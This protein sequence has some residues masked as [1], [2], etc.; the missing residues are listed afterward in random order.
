MFLHA[1]LILVKHLLTF[2]VIICLRICR[3]FKNNK[4]RTTPIET[5]AIPYDTLDVSK[6]DK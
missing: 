1:N 6:M 2:F 4:D 3:C 5:F